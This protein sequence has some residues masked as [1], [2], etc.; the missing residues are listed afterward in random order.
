MTASTGVSGVRNSW[1]RVARKWSLAWLAASASRRARST[2]SSAMR[3]AVMSVRVSTQPSTPP[4]ASS[5]PALAWK[6]QASPVS[7][8]SEASIPCTTCP[9]KTSA[10]GIAGPSPGASRTRGKASEKISPTGLQTHSR[11]AARLARS[12]RSS[13]SQTTIASVA[14]SKIELASFSAA[15]I[16]WFRFCSVRSVTT[17]Q[18]VS[19]SSSGSALA[20]R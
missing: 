10:K 8:V 9:A 11:R 14:C 15:T 19:T 3:R 6:R 2:S 7:R 17:R 16:S 4:G 1:L 18:T 5:G 20:A 13:A 12:T